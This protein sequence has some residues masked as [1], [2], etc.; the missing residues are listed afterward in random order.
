MTPGTV[1]SG[2]VLSVAVEAGLHAECFYSFRRYFCHRDVAVADFAFDPSDNHMAAVRVE[3]MRRLAKK[4]LPFE[5]FTRCQQ[6]Y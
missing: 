2:L 5:W 6:L 3:D 1:R 4:R